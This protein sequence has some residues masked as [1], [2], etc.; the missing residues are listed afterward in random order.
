V[1]ISKRRRFL[2]LQR[3]GFRCRYCGLRSPEAVLEVDH[4]T[5]VANGGRDDFDNL[6][7]S[8]RDCNR[9]KGVINVG[10]ITPIEFTDQYE[11]CGGWPDELPEFL[12]HPA[13]RLPL[14][15]D[16][17]PFA[18]AGLAPANIQSMLPDEVAKIAEVFDVLY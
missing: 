13:D 15:F 3:D 16:L 4:I 17:D 14:F 18:V 10:F 2:V 6:I 5:A 7:T 1:A 11:Y 9:G 12:Y 8:C